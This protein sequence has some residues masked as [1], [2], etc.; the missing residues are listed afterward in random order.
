MKDYIFL[1]LELLYVLFFILIAIKIIYENKTSSKTWAYLLLI[2]ILP[3]G[4]AIIYLIFGVNFTKNRFYRYKIAYNQKNIEDIRHKIQKSSEEVLEKNSDLKHYS[5]TISFLLNYQYSPITDGNTVEILINGEEKFKKLKEV[6][7]KAKH[8]I[9]MEYYIFENDVIGNEVVDILINKK[10]EGV[11]VRFLYDDFGSHKLRHL[12]KRMHAEGIEALPVNKVTFT[13]LANRINYRDHRKIVV[14]DGIYGFVGGIN[15]SDRYIN[16]Q[17]YKQ[18]YWRDTHLFIE[19]NGVL[20]LQYLFISSWTFAKKEVENFKENYFHF[21]IKTKETNLVQIAAS[22]PDASISAIEY[23]TISSIYHA[24]KCIYITTPYFIPTESLLQ[25]LKAIAF[26]GVD[27]RLLIPEKGDSFVVQYASNSYLNDLLEVG[28]K[29]YQYQKG[30]VHAKTMVIDDEISIIGTANMD[31]RS[32]ELN[33][34]VN[35]MVYNSETNQK[36]KKVFFDDLKNAKEIDKEEWKKRNHFIIFTEKFFRL[37][38][39]LL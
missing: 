32:Q 23:S 18:V 20:Y 16:D 38:S 8:H 5:N 10:K 27:V 36:L 13:L 12:I 25:T 3:I 30:F 21:N 17:N 1:F 14:V 9:H 15:V 11:E 4:G 26:A 33:F 31:V 28:I 24:K 35:A 22:G 29:V 19:G 2:I 39:P 7:L 34:E 37:L 6:L